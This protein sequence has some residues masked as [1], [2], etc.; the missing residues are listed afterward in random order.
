M[1]PTPSF[2]RTAHDH[3][4][5]AGRAD[6]PQTG[7]PSGIGAQLLARWPSLLAAGALVANTS[8][9][10]DSHVTAMVIILAAMCYPAAAALGSRRS[11]WAMIVL[12]SVAVFV[13]TPV[14]VDPTTM[15][16]V[17]GFGFGG[18]GYLRGSAVDRREVGVQTLGFAVFT[19]VALTAMMTDPWVSAHLA[20]LAAIGHAGWDAVHFLRDTV[21]TRSFT[22]FCFLLDLGL[23]LLLL[24][25]TWE[26]LPL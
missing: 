10:V 12:A 15:L 6:H 13:A 1:E 24:L 14:G 20:A 4:R 22:E 26:V 17:A 21:V 2:P 25:A 23:G 11:G 19:A 18:V 9:G 5:P 16:I 8:G 3:D 7:H